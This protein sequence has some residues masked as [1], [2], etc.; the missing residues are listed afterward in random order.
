MGK[1]Q[2]RSA[3]AAGKTKPR[4]QKP[5]ERAWL[6]PLIVLVGALAVIALALVAAA[7]K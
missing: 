4:R 2:R 7:D 3:E 1:K 6:V 5:K